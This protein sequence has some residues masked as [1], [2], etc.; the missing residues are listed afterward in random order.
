MSV[1]YSIHN[2]IAKQ[3]LVALEQQDYDDFFDYDIELVNYTNEIEYK[4]A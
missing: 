4:A 2:A 3:L 1:P